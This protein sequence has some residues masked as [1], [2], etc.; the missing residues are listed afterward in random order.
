MARFVG[1]LISTILILSTAIIAFGQSSNATM[2]GS[3][4]DQKGAVIPGA[5]V[6]VKNVDTGFTRTMVTES[7]GKFRFPEIPIGAYEITVEAK[8]FAKLV[9][10]GVGL[11]VNQV[12][13]LDLDLR[14]G[15]LEEVV[16]VTE[17]A[18]L[19]NSTT[20][21]VATRFDER[22]L[23]ELPIAPNRNVMNVLLSVPGVS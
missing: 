18:P 8:G 23:S 3:I 6:T 5:T 4:V 1:I 20:P 21:E 22:P 11:L 10:T 7:D 16:T 15:G 9:R 12:A 13:V 17:D 14:P 2:S 19:L